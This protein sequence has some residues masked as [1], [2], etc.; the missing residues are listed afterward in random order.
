[1]YENYKK[2]CEGF[3]INLSEFIQICQD[4]ESDTKMCEMAFQDFDTDKNCIILLN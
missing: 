3:A 2:I 4:I 1:M